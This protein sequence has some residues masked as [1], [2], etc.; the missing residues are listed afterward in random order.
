MAG[1]VSFLHF[2]SSELSALASEHVLAALTKPIAGLS[3]TSS[4][5]WWRS[6]LVYCGKR[7]KSVG[8]Q[9]PLFLGCKIG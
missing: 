1:S 2:H 9:K 6:Q 4:R 7:T 8:F 5:K 3:S